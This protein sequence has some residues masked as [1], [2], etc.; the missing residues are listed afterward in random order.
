MPTNSGSWWVTWANA[1]ATNS[2]SIDDLESSFQDSAKGFIKALKD[3]G[4]SVVV[5]TTKRSD[6][7]A[8]LFHWAWKIS[9]DKCKPSD[10]TTMGGVDIAWDLGDDARSK[11]AAQEMV[12]GFGLAVP[13]K[14]TVAPSLTSNHIAG[15][16]ID[17][18]ITWSGSI[19]L[20]K[21]DG[22]EEAVTYKSDVNTNTDL[23][24]IGES[25]G[26]KKLTNDAPHWSFDGR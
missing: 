4:A 8:Y 5:T 17:M 25:Y 7:R 26:V 19:N 22:T 16:A 9:Q 13:P 23:H 18:T 10:A 21:K 24:K 6:K 11:I 20:K 14:S 1:H 3:A 2:D 12:D 15:K